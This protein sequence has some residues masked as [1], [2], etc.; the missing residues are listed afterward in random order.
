MKI[1]VLAGLLL[2]AFFAG[3]SS[4]QVAARLSGS[5]EDPTGLPVPGATV[6]VLLPGGAK[7]IL[8]ATTT[9]EGIFAF[10]A[11]PPSTYNLV[12]SAE[13]ATRRPAKEVAHA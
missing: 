6:D 13:P 3:T 5:V 4:A 10:I 11:V 9:A 2:A 12:V 8:T 1:R 7:P